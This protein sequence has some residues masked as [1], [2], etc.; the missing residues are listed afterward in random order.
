MAEP[1][2]PQ[3]DEVTSFGALWRAWRKARRAKRGRGGEPAFYLNLE[4]NLLKLSEALQNRVWTPDP[5]RYFRLRKT[6]QRVVSEASFRDRVVHHALVGALEPV[7]EA[8]FHDHSYA[9]RKGKGQHAA[10]RRV[11]NLAS[12]HRYALRLDIERYFD[13]VDHEVLLGQLGEV[14][15]DEGILWLCRRL[16]E[17]ARVPTVPESCGH[18]VPIG[19]LTSQFWAN[20]YLD[21]LDHRLSGACP[22]Y[23]RFMDDYVALADDKVTLWHLAEEAADHL[24]SALKLKL[25]ARA[26]RVAPVREGI[27]WLGFRIYPG[28]VRLDR[29]G[30]RRFG[31]KIA[32]S[33]SRATQDEEAE[34]SRS[35]SLCGHLMAGHTRALRREILYRLDG[36]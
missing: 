18:G 25:K 34:V 2:P 24:T 36:A 32:A 1:R 10:I 29:R 7:F 14:I 12:R 17:E 16:L 21:G 22:A 19:N 33:A 13:A 5:Y 11:Q 20:V 23:A 15:H 35:A 27:P 8:R 28:L 31:R 9:C 4:E 30:R 6:K 26:T 3:Y